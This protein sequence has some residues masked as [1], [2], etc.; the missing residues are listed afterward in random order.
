MKKSVLICII[1]YAVMLA[2][3]MTGCG[4]DNSNK[5]I[6]VYEGMTVSSTIEIAQEPYGR[7]ELLG[8]K[9]THGSKP[10]GC[11]YYADMGE[12]VYVHIHIKNPDKFE[13]LSFTFNGEKYSDYMFEEGSNMETIIIKV[14]VGRESGIKKHTIDA[15]KYVDGT[16]IKDVIIKGNQTISVHVSTDEYID[17]SATQDCKHE[18]SSKIIEVEGKPAT[19]REEGLTKGTKCTICNT[20]IIPQTYTDTIECIEGD[21]ILDKEPTKSEDGLRH[22]ECIMCQTTISEEILYAIGSSGL[23]YSKKT[24]TECMVMGIGECTDEDIVIPKYY[25]GKLVTLIH[26][27]AFKNCTSIKSVVLPDSVLEIGERAFSGCISLANIEIPDSVLEIGRSAFS[28]CT[29]LSNIEIPDSVTTLS[30]YAFENCTSLIN[31]RLSNS[32]TTIT[33]LTFSGCTSLTSITIPDS[34]TTMGASVFYD[35]TSLTNVSLPNSLINIKYSPF[36]NC[37]SLKYTE[38]NGALY[39]GNENNPYVVLVKAANSEITSC[40]INKDTN[41][42]LPYA[43]ENCCSLTRVTIPNSVTSIGDYAF[44]GCQSLIIYCEAASKPSTWWS[45]NW[46]SSIDYSNWFSSNIPVVWG[47]QE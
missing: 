3:I 32:L 46:N 6:P 38:F 18:D 34:V 9:D 44:Q 37:P 23:L 17:N 7:F 5:T 14:N 25:D 24:E 26:E 10:E 28:G 47:Y 16:E 45:S 21:W 41:I 2:G 33:G 15:I 36:D 29:S 4:T 31:V 43:F 30:S 22:T 8:Y 1:I 42:I 20:M 35:C 27:D 39:L 40:E 11:D 19:C 13:I 12:N